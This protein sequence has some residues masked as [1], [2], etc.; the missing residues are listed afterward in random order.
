VIVQYCGY[1]VYYPIEEETSQPITC[2]L[3]GIVETLPLVIVVL[4]I[5]I[6][7]VLR[8]FYVCA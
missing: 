2:G 1:Y 8:T 3:I 5:F 7:L 6:L 4:A